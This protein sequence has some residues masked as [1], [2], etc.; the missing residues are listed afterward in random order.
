MLGLVG[1][2]FFSLNAWVRVVT[3]ALAGLYWQST[4]WGIHISRGGHPLGQ[5]YLGIPTSTTPIT[6]FKILLKKKLWVKCSQMVQPHSLLEWSFSVKRG[7]RGVPANGTPTLKS[8][9]FIE[10]TN[11]ID[12]VSPFWT[13]H[14]NYYPYNHSPIQSRN[15]VL[16]EDLSSRLTPCCRPTFQTFFI[17]FSLIKF[18]I[19]CSNCGFESMIQTDHQSPS[20]LIQTMLCGT[21]RQTV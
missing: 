13:G 19:Y 10:V 7:A 15:S 9:I 1:R 6:H 14:V 16:G 11:P 12:T 21:A 17:L 20:V 5:G 4:S 3:T 8:D 2:S 18:R